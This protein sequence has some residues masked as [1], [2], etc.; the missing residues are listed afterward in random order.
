MNFK[1][2]K[3][4]NRKLWKMYF[5]DEITFE[6]R[7]AQEINI[8]DLVRN[9]LDTDKDLDKFFYILFHLTN[10]NGARALLPDFDDFRF[11]DDKGEKRYWSGACA[12]YSKLDN[13]HSRKLSEYLGKHKKVNWWSVRY[14]VIGIKEDAKAY[15]EWKEEKEATA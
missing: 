1:E 15:Q 13:Y 6:E 9:E 5:N 11:V 12:L 10:P 4:H 7:E 14:E 2:A 3:K 8:Y